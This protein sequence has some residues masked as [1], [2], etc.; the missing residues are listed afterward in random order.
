MWIAFT[1]SARKGHSS[2]KSQLHKLSLMW[3]GSARQ[4]GVDQFFIRVDSATTER[5]PSGPASRTG[6]DQMNEKDD[7]IA[8]P[9]RSE[10]SIS[11]SIVLVD[12]EV[13][14]LL[15]AWL[16]FVDTRLRIRVQPPAAPD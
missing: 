14:I 8:H 6:D 4:D 16:W 7:D 11:A 13:Q 9:A 1:L 10:T 12:D 5:S 2:N 3:P 15:D